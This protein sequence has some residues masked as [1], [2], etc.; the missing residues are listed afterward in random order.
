LRIRLPILERKIQKGGSLKVQTAMTRIEVQRPALLIKILKERFFF[1]F[2]GAWQCAG[3]S[4]PDC[5]LEQPWARRVS[6]GASKLW[7]D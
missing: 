4:F 2:F 7:S 1:S 6:P 3:G 5:L